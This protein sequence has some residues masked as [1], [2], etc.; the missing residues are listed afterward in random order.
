MPLAVMAHLAAFT[1]PARRHLTSSAAR[2]PGA[3]PAAP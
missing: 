1:A 3:T 2:S